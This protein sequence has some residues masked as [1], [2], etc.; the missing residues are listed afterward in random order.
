MHARGVRG[1]VQR[2]AEAAFAACGGR[3]YARVDFMLSEA[4][5]LYLLEINT[6]PGMKETS[7]LPMSGRCAGMDFAGLVR[8]MVSPALRRF[9]V[10]AP[11][12]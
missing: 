8:E 4:G 7:L 5:E 2:A 1:R 3:D 10:A 11:A 6:L 12:L 9:H